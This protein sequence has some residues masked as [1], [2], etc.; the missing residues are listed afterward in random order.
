[1]N[2]Q[3]EGINY[4]KKSFGG[5]LVTHYNMKNIIHGLINLPLKHMN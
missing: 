3:I 5:E 1:M 4:F 2:P